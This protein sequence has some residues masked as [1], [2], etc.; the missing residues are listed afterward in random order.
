MINIAACVIK[1]DNEC[2]AKQ[3]E[4]QLQYLIDEAYTALQNAILQDKVLKNIIKTA[5]S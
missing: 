1:G 3:V 4:I 5:I 2:L